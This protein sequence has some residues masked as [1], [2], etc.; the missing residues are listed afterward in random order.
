MSQ[1]KST[2]KR[3]AKKGSNPKTKPRWQQKGASGETIEVV[4]EDNQL[5]SVLLGKHDEHLALLESQLNVVAAPRGNIIA[6]TGAPEDCESAKQ[7]LDDLYERINQGLEVGPGDVEG[8]IRMTLKPLEQG[9]SGKQVFS[10]SVRIDTRRR[11]V[12]PRSTAQ[13]EYIKE[14][15]NK[16]LTFGTGP[17]GTGKTYLAVAVAAAALEAGKVDRIILSRPAVEAGER[18]GFLPGDMR[19]KIDPYL[20][21]LFDALYDMMSSDKV[22]RGMETGEIEIAPLAFMRGRTL[23]NSFIIL[24]EAQNCTTQQMKMFLTRLGEGSYMAIT[25]DPSQTDLPPG[26]PSGLSQAVDLLEGLDDVAHIAF[27][28]VDVV[29][30]SLVA[31]IVRAYDQLGQKKPDR[32]GEAKP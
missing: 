20:R 18:L 26:T 15:Q 12:T 30:H 25:G 8:A 13:A 28:D 2:T 24:D 29:R 31:Q 21:P 3:R 9:A 1:T 10:T 7:V 11:T 22:V 17:A 5:L 32:R 23:S 19:E 6:I 14:L 27:R 16:E 4:F